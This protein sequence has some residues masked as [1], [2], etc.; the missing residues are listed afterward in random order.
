METKYI[1]HKRKHI[2]ITDSLSNKYKEV[3]VPKSMLLIPIDREWLTKEKVK[4]MISS[5][6]VRAKR[7]GWDFNLE[8]DDIKIPFLCPLLGI[9]LKPGEGKF[10]DSSPTVDRI[11]SN[12]GYIKGNVRIISHK[13]NRMKNDAT[14]E[15]LTT[16]ANSIMAYMGS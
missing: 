15:D 2:K 4:Q 12:K 6:K 10:C 8:P 9:M 14:L 16:F 13:A 3:Q 7:K 5:C 11:D 1:I